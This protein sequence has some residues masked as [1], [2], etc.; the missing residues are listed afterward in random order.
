MCSG[1]VGTAQRVHPQV[2]HQTMRCLLRRRLALDDPPY[3]V[4]PPD[5]PRHRWP[6]HLVVVAFEERSSVIDMPCDYPGNP[7]V[8]M[9][10]ENQNEPYRV[11]HSN[12]SSLDLASSTWPVT[13]SHCSKC[14]TILNSFWTSLYLNK[15]TAGGLARNRAPEQ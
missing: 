7:F 6:D 5:G 9:R 8:A 2:S 12:E 15:G 11:L 14:A 13:W 4:T 10:P 3:P 1:Q